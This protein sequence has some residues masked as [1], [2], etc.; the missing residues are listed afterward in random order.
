MTRGLTAAAATAAAEETV[1]RVVAVAL[2]FPSGFVRWNS[3]TTDFTIG[4]QIFYG[5]GG[6]GN[7]G[8][9][10]EGVELRSFGITAT[11]TG[12]PRDMVSLALGQAYQGRSGTVWEIQLDQTTWQPIANPQIIFRGRMDQMDITMGETAQVSVRLE[13]RL[14]DW[15]RARIQRYTDAEQ[16]RR[17]QNDGSFRFVSTATEKEIVWP[18]QAF[19]TYWQKQ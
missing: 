7:I 3:S 14:T 12:I 9:A 2:D 8:P 13:N 17:D 5:V 16:R 10:E 19:W 4:G 18:N 15:E 1:T 6:I 11:L